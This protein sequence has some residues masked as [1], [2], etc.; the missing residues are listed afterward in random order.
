MNKRIRQHKQGAQRKEKEERETVEA[1]SEAI[2][3]EE[4]EQQVKKDDYGFFTDH[5]QDQKFLALKQAS[6][7]N[8][9]RKENE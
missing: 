6:K 9:F 4:K 5:A 8:F 7:L 2:Q 1:K 3:E